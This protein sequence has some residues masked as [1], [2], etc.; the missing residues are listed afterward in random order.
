ME[1]EEVK[2]EHH[3]NSE[4]IRF[5][6][7]CGAEGVGW[8]SAKELRCGAC[9]F[10]LF[11][12]MAA[13]VAAIIE[14]GD[15]VLL[16][17]RRSDPC[18][19]MLDLPGGFVD[20][21]ETGEAAV[22]RELREELGIEVND[23]A[24]LFSLPNIYPYRNVTYHTLDMVFLVRLDSIPEIAPADDVLDVL[25]VARDSIDP[26]AI[27]FPSIRAALQRYASAAPE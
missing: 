10:V 5:C 24:Y 15:R 27:G 19:G 20:F 2:V 23:P 14:C 8:N 4:V 18:R 6:P 12:N 17:V 3:A 16:T 9:G 13:A 26:S 11:H 22:R 7:G 25:W 21:G 1:S